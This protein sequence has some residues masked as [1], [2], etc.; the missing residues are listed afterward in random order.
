MLTATKAFNLAPSALALAT[1]QVRGSVDRLG[2]PL[3]LCY[4]DWA[5]P[6]VTDPVGRMAGMRQ[7]QSQQ[8]VAQVGVS[9]LRSGPLAAG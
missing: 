2:G 8:L 5:N 4:L 7:L 9:S 3:G 6:F 1:A